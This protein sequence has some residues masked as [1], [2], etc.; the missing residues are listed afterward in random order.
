[1]G[2]QEKIVPGEFTPLIFVHLILEVQYGAR[3]WLQGVTSSQCAP[4]E[5][6][7]GPTPR[8]SL[9]QREGPG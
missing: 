3:P 2:P 9:A 5:Y 1:M 8:E 7:G 4:C 6:R